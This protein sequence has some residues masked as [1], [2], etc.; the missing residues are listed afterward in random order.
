MKK[1]LFLIIISFLFIGFTSKVEASAQLKSGAACG[2]CG[3]YF[4]FGDPKPFSDCMDR[5]SACF[6]KSKRMPGQSVESCM[7]SAQRDM[8]K[9]YPPSYRNQKN[10][11]WIMDTVGAPGS[12]FVDPDERNKFMNG[13]ATVGDWIDQMGDF[14]GRWGEIGSGISHAVEDSDKPVSQRIAGGVAA[15]LPEGNSKTVAG[16]VNAVSSLRK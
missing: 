7:C 6:K 3:Y 13:D 1:I 10:A 15:V 8:E 5:M 2:Y 12:G 4:I 14:G 9:K 11:A 16:F